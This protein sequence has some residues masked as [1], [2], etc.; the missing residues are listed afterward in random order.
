LNERKR[1]QQ[2]DDKMKKSLAVI[3]YTAISNDKETS[4]SSMPNQYARLKNVAKGDDVIK[5]NTDQ[6]YAFVDEFLEE[7]MKRSSMYEADEDLDYEYCSSKHNAHATPS[8][9]NFLH[10]KCMNLLLLYLTE[11]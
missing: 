10:N 9:S 11:K 2:E 6:N 5:D 7:E 8:I 3:I 1:Q 4:N